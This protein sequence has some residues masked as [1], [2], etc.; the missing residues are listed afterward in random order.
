M[1]E[2]EEKYLGLFNDSFPPVMDGVTLTVTH[3]ADWLLQAGL[4]PCVVTP[5]SPDKPEVPYPVL[6]YFSLPIASRHPYRYGY[7]RLDFSIRRRLRDTPFALVHAHSPFSAGRLALQTARRQGVPQV[8]TFHSKFR[9]DL[10]H[11]LRFFPSLVNWVMKRLVNFSSRPM[12]FGFRRPE[13][14]KP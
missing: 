14:R 8:A 13:W 9:T 5:D 2:N 1:K 10:E 12:R 6:R 7:P 11:S 3:Y 4:R